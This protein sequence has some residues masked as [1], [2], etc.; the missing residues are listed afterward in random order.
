MAHANN[1]AA[2]NGGRARSLLFSASCICYFNTS[3][4]SSPVHCKR[5]VCMIHM[6][7]AYYGDKYGVQH[8]HTYLSLYGHQYNSV[9][10]TLPFL[11]C[12]MPRLGFPQG[13][14]SG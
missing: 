9:P 1:V 3:S 14:T 4:I 5:K 7:Y 6:W 12:T 10:N 8:V 2:S 13:D 11:Q